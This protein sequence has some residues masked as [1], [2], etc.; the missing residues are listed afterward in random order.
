MTV[1]CDICGKPLTVERKPEGGGWLKCTPP[2]NQAYEFF[3]DGSDGYGYRCFVLGRL[4]P[5]RMTTAWSLYRE[6]LDYEVKQFNFRADARLA[7]GMIGYAQHAAEIGVF[8]AQV[9]ETRRSLPRGPRRWWRKFW[10]F[11]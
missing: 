6:Y 5:S 8:R 3:P 7:L 10:R 2:C 11:P 1:A 9:E 4:Y